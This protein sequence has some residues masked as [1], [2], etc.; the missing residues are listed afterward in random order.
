MD[1]VISCGQDKQTNKLIV[2]CGNNK[3]EVYIYEIVGSDLLLID[4]IITDISGL[5]KDA[6]GVPYKHAIIRNAVKV[7]NDCIVVSNECGELQVYKHSIKPKPIFDAS[8]L[9][10]TQ[11]DAEEDLL[12][13]SKP[14]KKSPAKGFKPY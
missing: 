10:M 14:I 12:V 7:S 11:E 13:A 5:G 9:H 4:M 3:G 8:L 6:N 2:Y 1:Y